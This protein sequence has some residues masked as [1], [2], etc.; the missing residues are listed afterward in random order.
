M[1]AKGLKK[2]TDRLKKLSSA[3]IEQ[4]AGAVAFEGADIIRAE[5]FRMVSAGSVSGKNH[6][7]S[8][9]GEAPNR[10]TGDLQ[11]GFSTARTSRTSAEF[12]SDSGH[13]R[14]LEFGTSRM[15]ARPHIR[16]A[17]DKKA[18]AVQKRFAAQMKKLVKASG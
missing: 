12:R 5:A 17:R 6:V 10:D 4:L 3:S 16:P 7:A 8:K 14:P 13:A 15:A 2:H 11:A 18:D 9:P 1:A